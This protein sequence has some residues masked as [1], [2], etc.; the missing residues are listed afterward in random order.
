MLLTGGQIHLVLIVIHADVD[1]VG[2]QLLIAR[3][4]F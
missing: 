1:D 4:H 3:D 2:Q